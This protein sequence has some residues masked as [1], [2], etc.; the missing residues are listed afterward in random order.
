MS[1]YMYLTAKE[2]HI[3]NIRFMPETLIKFLP[4]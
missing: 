1:L 3:L 2:T 4:K